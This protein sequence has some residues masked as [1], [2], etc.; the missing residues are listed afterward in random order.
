MGIWRL[1]HMLHRQGTHPSGSNPE[2]LDVDRCTAVVQSTCVLVQ[3]RGTAGE[4]DGF[5]CAHMQADLA[6]SNKV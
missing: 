3:L 6:Y 2:E 4:A 1:C 5:S